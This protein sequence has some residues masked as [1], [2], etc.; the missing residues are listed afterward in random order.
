M[1][2]NVCDQTVGY[3]AKCILEIEKG[4]NKWTTMLN[5]IID[6]GCGSKD[7]LNSAIYTR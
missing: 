5:S 3:W 4:N 1:S 6:Y 7:V 2:K